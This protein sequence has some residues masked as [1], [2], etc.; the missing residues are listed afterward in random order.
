[1]SPAC[2][3]TVRV[4]TRAT[5]RSFYSA[6]SLVSQVRGFRVWPQRHHQAQLQELP[7]LPREIG[8]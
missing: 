5:S 2:C 4:L 8:D 3:H 6:K 7:C 1:M